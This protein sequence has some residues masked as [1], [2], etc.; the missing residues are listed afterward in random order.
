MQN[1]GRI[2]FDQLHLLWVYF[3][4]EFYLKIEKMFCAKSGSYLK[5]KVGDWVYDLCYDSILR[6]KAGA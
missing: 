5:W 2:Y 4:L 3:D 1:Y 6:D